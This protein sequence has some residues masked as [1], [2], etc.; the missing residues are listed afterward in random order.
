MCP[1]D[2]VKSSQTQ[3]G[4]LTLYPKLPARRGVLS[5]DEAVTL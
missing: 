1:M 5:L 3:A 2:V 4:L